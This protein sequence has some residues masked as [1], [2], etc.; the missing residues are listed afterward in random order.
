M[1]INNLKS[2]L[3]DLVLIE[4]D[5]LFNDVKF[6]ESFANYISHSIDRRFFLNNDNKKFKKIKIKPVYFIIEFIM[7]IILIYLTR[8]YLKLDFLFSLILVS[9]VVGS[10]EMMFLGEFLDIF[11][12]FMI[13]FKVKFKNYSGL[14]IYFGYNLIQIG[15]HPTKENLIVIRQISENTPEVEMINSKLYVCHGSRVYNVIFDFTTNSKQDNFNYCKS[16]CLDDFRNYYVNY[17]SGRIVS[18]K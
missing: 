8:S 3:T 1:K 2:I 10:L 6:R 13:T 17:C 4:E 15:Y 12:R 18:K 7:S 11:K 9:L 14:K 16:L 5:Y